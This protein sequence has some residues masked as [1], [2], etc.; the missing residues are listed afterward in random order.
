MRANPLAKQFHRP[1]KLLCAI[2]CFVVCLSPL[3]LASQTE[4][5]NVSATRDTTHG[6]DLTAGPVRLQI[7]VLAPGVVRIRYTADGTNPPEDSFAVLPGAFPS[8]PGVKTTQSG[9]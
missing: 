3:S 8:T 7:D 9:D 6:L 1:S 2:F 5:G 4:P